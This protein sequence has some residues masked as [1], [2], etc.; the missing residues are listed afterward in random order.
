MTAPPDADMTK[1]KLMM[2]PDDGYTGNS[3]PAANTLSD[4]LHPE[5]HETAAPPETNPEISVSEK[6]P[7]ETCAIEASMEKQMC[8]TTE[9]KEIKKETE[10]AVKTAKQ[11]LEDK[12]VKEAQQKADAKTAHMTKEDAHKV[13]SAATSS[14]LLTKSEN[15]AMALAEEKAE[16]KKIY[17][18]Q[19]DLEKKRQSAEKAFKVKLPM[20]DM[21][22]RKHK[23]TPM[24]YEALS[25][26]VEKCRKSTD[27]GY[28]KCAVIYDNVP[29]H[30]HPQRPWNEFSAF[31]NHKVKQAH[32]AG[33][34]AGHNLHH[35]KHLGKDEG[36]EE[37]AEDDDDDDDYDE[38]DG[39]EDED[40]TGVSPGQVEFEH[41]K[42]AEENDKNDVI[43]GEAKEE[44]A[45]ENEKEKK[46]G[47][48]PTSLSGLAVKKAT[49]KK[50]ADGNA[51]IK[52]FGFDS[53]WAESEK[54]KRTQRREEK[55]SEA[56]MPG[57]LDR[58]GYGH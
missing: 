13:E 20:R 16:K 1:E 30:K 33:H 14:E 4:I 10:V 38:E 56:K 31:D 40:W 22:E 9:L 28:H 25:V 18:E 11:S 2:L 46:E 12:M 5:Q 15:A 52:E 39:Y 55:T 26:V 8:E 29:M 41:E 45:A 49:K 3:A 36:E 47:D 53:K 51:V 35:V 7:E 19:I 24:C 23:K 48:T 32:A 57:L 50:Q 43:K 54:A 21:N 44:R 34:V 27:E 6:S 58:T 17:D 37:D 42:K